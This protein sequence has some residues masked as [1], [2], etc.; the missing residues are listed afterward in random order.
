MLGR[1]AGVR[2]GDQDVFVSVAGGAR[3]PDPAAD[4]AIALAVPLQRYLRNP[5]SA[6]GRAPGSV[7]LAAIASIALWSATIVSGRLMAY[8]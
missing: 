7:R 2:L 8:F 1:H 6:T 5:E 4:L 3:A